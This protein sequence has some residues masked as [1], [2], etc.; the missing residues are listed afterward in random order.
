MYHNKFYDDRNSIP[1]LHFP[2]NLPSFLIQNKSKPSFS[3][4]EKKILNGVCVSAPVYSFIVTIS[5][6]SIRLLAHGHSFLA[7]HILNQFR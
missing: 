2:Q 3:L 4:G 5:P 7:T 1:I 6:E